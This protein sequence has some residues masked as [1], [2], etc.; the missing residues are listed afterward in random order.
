MSDTFHR[1]SMPGDAWPEGRHGLDRRPK[2]GTDA[3][4][5]DQYELSKAALGDL[6]F[7]ERDIPT[8]DDVKDRLDPVTRGF[9]ADR[10]EQPGVKDELFI[11]PSVGY[12]GLRGTHRQPGLI[13]RFDSGQAAGDETTLNA[14]S[15]NMVWG[16]RTEDKS[17]V[18]DNGPSDRFQVGVLLG[19]SALERGLVHAGLTTSGQVDALQQERDDLKA[20]RGVTVDPITVGQ[21]IAINAQRRHAGDPMLDKG[22]SGTRLVH[23]PPQSGRVFQHS[24]RSP[25]EFMESMVARGGN[26]RT[27]V[28]PLVTVRGNHMALTDHEAETAKPGVGV[29]RTLRISR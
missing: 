5:Q 29:R 19:D 13:P 20:S 14:S 16:W 18:H 28:V 6:G 17:P 10:G 9:L 26:R 8:L 25:H 23:Y 1:T 27:E 21:I 12:V 2:A 15:E 3:W 4:L 24:F 11:V 7:E 22:D